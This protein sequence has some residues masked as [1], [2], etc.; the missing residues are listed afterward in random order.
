MNE[1]WQYE[2]GLIL[3]DD[4]KQVL[5]DYGPNTIAETGEERFKFYIHKACGYHNYDFYIE[6]WN[7]NGK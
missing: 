7:K 4:L 3:F 1:I 2:F 5:W 6:E